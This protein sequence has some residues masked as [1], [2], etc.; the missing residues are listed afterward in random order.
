MSLIAVK[1]ATY[2][3]VF[4]DKKISQTTQIKSLS[5]KPILAYIKH[6][7]ISAVKLWSGANPSSFIA[8][9]EAHHRNTE[10]CYSVKL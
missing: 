3:P 8:L 6:I 9:A 4:A 1:N 5:R 2:R 10:S 7:G